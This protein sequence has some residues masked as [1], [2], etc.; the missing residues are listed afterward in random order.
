MV[1]VPYIALPNLLMSQQVDALVP[2]LI[3]SAAT[4]ETIAHTLL[5]M[6]TKNNDTCVSAIA[7]FTRIHQR[8][9]RQ[10]N[11]DPARTGIT[12]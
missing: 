4:P 3:Q 1:K 12:I 2:E 8:L 5:P 10:S 9:Q 11:A 6:M 7:E